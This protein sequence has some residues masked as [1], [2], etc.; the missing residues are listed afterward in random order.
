[1]IMVKV[2]D[3]VHGYADG[4]FGRDS[5]ACRIIEAVGTD[6]IVTRNSSGAA[7]F[8][9]LDFLEAIDSDDR[10]YCSQQC[11][12]DDERDRDRCARTETHHPHPWKI[13]HA[14]DPT[15]DGRTFICPGVPV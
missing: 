10:S 14:R 7:E 5:Y 12:N 4:I 8:G 2:G 13:A 3:Q 11:G 6:W 15:Y 9:R 1:M